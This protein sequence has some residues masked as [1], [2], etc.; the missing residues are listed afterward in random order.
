MA[1][2][3]IT[4][5]LLHHALALAMIGFLGILPPSHGNVCDIMRTFQIVF[6]RPLVSPSKWMPLNVYVGQCNS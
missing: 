1:I 5:T 6:V 4:T 3:T 2:H